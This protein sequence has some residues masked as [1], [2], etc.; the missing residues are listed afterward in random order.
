MRRHGLVD[1]PDALGLN[2]HACWGFDDVG[3]LA[4][5]AASFLSE[6]SELGQRLMFVGGPEAEAMVRETDPMRSL[7]RDG[8]LQVAP[9]DAIYPGGRR[10]PHADQL[11]MYAGV[12][13]QALADGFTGL[14]VLAEVTTL[15]SPDGAWPGQVGW[16]SHADRYMATRP[17]AA[18][19]C[20]D[21][22]R[23][24]AEVMAALGSA[25]PVT[26][27]RLQHLAPFRVYAQS[28]AM[29]LAGEVDAF[30]STQL[31]ALLEMTIPVTEGEVVLDLAGL[32]FIDH[33][34]VR[35]VAELERRMCEHGATLTLRGESGL[36]RRLSDLLG[37][38]S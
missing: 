33:S 35:A 38:E 34:G 7:V 22:R 37:A 1:S 3:E 19:C 10:L 18:L 31:S 27:R 9:F 28:D 32:D 15:A 20:F 4:T 21:R 16:E 26:D 36:F 13:D 8:T 30:S 12:T 17:L 5:A 11:S 6:G 2:G 23:L 24:P 25:H 29:A 14:R